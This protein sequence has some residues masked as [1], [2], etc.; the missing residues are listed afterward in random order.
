MIPAAE[1]A[2]MDWTSLVLTGIIIF[3][4][5]AAAVW[6]GWRPL[7]ALVL[8]QEQRFGKVLRGRL[9]IDIQPRTA[10]VLWLAGMAIF[11]GLG[12]AV[13]R[14]FLGALV[15]AVLAAAAP[16]VLLRVLCR[17]RLNRLEDQLV[18]GIQ[19]LSAGIRADLNMVQA[20]ELL[21]EDGPVPLR[22]EFVHL[23]REYEYGM[24][25]EEA[26]N[27]TAVRI[28]SGDFRLLFSALLT[29]RERGGNL[30]ETLDRIADSIREIQR[31]EGRVEAL[32]AQGRANARFL[33]GLVAV[34]L[35]ILYLIDPTS[36]RALFSDDIG[37]VILAAIVVL[38][39]AGFAWV[40]KI[41]SIDI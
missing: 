41:S 6:I 21:A 18:T 12:L 14:S 11:A 36:V 20:M 9:L 38:M 7:Q 32:T 1:I 28:G 19:T 22:Q 4:G 8:L 30:A 15:G 24:P 3:T 40:K 39:A 34:V 2:P 31:L 16:T 37:K 26:M 13:T 17:R 5:T 23:L 33:G 29:H 27:R 10:T 35:A 25:L